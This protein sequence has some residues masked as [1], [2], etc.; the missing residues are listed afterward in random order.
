M[1]DERPVARARDAVRTDRL[2]PDVVAGGELEVDVAGHDLERLAHLG[3]DRVA[4]LRRVGDVVEVAAAGVGELL[5]EPLVE[6]VAD[7]EGRGR[8]ATG[9]QLGGMVRQ[10]LEVGDA[11]VREAVG[12]EQAA[13]DAEVGQVPRDL[14]AAAQPALAEVGAAAGLDGGEPIDRAAPRFRGRRRR[15]RSTTSTTSS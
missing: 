14:F 5:E 4:D 6:V 3:R 7:P 10:L 8:D 9:A 13:V 2:D 1:R 15:I 11:D 12:E